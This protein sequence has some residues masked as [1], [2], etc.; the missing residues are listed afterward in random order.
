MNH[1]KTLVLPVAVL[2]ALLCSA[3]SRDPLA[4][5]G[6]VVSDIKVVATALQKEVLVDEIQALGTAGANES[7]AIKPRVASIVT[8][9]AFEEGQHVNEGDLLVELEN[10]EIRAGLAVAE[11]ALSESRG[12]YNRS[13]T[14]AS[15]QAISASNLEQLQA[16]MQV[17]LAQVAAAKARL[18]NTSIRAPFKGRI[19]LRRVSPGSFVDS[20]SI[21][22]TLDDTEII[23]LD[24]SIPEAFLSVVAE[25]M[26]IVA[27]SLVYPDQPFAGRVASI[28]TRLDPVARSVQVRAT[29]PNPDGLLKP[30]M[31]LT[32]NLQRDRG[33][34]LLAPE[35][36][37]VPERGLQYVYLVVDGKAR[38]Q[39]VTLGRRAPGWV[40]IVAG[41]S[42][43]DLL[44]VEGTHKVRDGTTVDVVAERPSRDFSQSSG[45]SR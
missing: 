28:D 33:A 27:T 36:A 45:N 11:A 32:V 26:N 23:K 43:G 15:T 6:S 2:S 40:E 7:V 42:E 5:G 39:E 35:A 31:F 10:S 29:L 4:A 3:C 17:N 21:I 34:V 20:S 25:G 14:L 44:I 18:A 9:I 16:S 38:L 37:I 13:L 24:F 30:G 19:G 1:V 41:A 8:R 12:L 22:T